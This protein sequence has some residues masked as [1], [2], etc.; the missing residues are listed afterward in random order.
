[1]LRRSLQLPLALLGTAIG[2]APRDAAPGD[3]TALRHPPALSFGLDSAVAAAPVCDAAAAT[4][5]TAAALPPLAGTYLLTLVATDG[6]RR[7][8][9]AHGRLWLARTSARDRSPRTGR[10]PAR[11]DTA[12]TPYVGATDLD[13]ATVGAPMD[14]ADT[15]NIPRPTSRDPIYPGVLVR[16]ASPPDSTG[17]SAAWPFFLVG[18]LHNTRDESGWVDGPGIVLVVQASGPASLVGRWG[19]W[20]RKVDGRGYFCLRQVGVTA[21]GAA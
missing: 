3:S 5:T 14:W 4:R 15:V 21:P 19:P 6:S 2:C 12:S 9:T 20:G 7:G 11:S 1:M 10:G 17:G 13:F 16:V 8:A 18:T